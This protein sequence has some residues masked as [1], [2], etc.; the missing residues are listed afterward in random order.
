[1]PGIRILVVDDASVYRKIVR[2]LL[3]TIPEVEVVG[4]A[5]NGA[6]ALEAIQKL[7]PDLVTLD[8]EM[9]ELDGFGVLA[10]IKRR[11]LSAGVIMLSSLT[12]QGAD[13]TMQALRAG[14]FDFVA[15][16][17]NTNLQLSVEA[18]RA[19]LLP[20]IEAFRRSLSPA[21][22]VKLPTEYQHGSRPLVE[23]VDVVAIGVSTGGP[24]TLAQL[25]AKL[26]A[27]LP[28]PVLI[29][30]HMPP[31][32]TKSL[33]AELNRSCPL[34]V[35]EASDGDLICA[36][37]VLFAPGGQH[38]RIQRT[39]NGCAIRIT[40]DPPEKSC[41]PSVDY[42]FRSVS[43]VYG[44]RSLAVVLTGMGDDGVRGCQAIKRQGGAVIAQDQASCV[45]FGMPRAVIESGL[46]D[47][48]MPLKDIPSQIVRYAGTANFAIRSPTQIAW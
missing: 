20:K 46:V 7:Q 47:T 31:I 23:R 41:K 6:L 35:C 21:V 19:E 29:V 26:P 42:L 8:F 12:K 45:V 22:K 25:L 32:F 36:G 3:A 17:S 1:M 30:Q 5:S 24:S 18:L 2:D 40:D 37:H 10:E 48:V 43:E 27:D 39:V 11:G 44:R 15:K 38:M 4:V 28:V 9:P 13:M 33:A 34:E 14:A 16:P